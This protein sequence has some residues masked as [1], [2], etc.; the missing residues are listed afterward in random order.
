M[1]R[2]FWWGDMVERNHLEDLG[3]DGK[4]ILKWILKKW[5]GKEWTGLLWFRIVT[6]GGALVNEV[7]NLQVP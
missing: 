3:I 6:G 5:D 1:P 7:I 2:G 4:M